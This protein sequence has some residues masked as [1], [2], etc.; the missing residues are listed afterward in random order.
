MEVNGNEITSAQQK[1]NTLQAEIDVAQWKIEGFKREI[2]YVLIKMETA[3]SENQMDHLVR[4]MKQLQ[5]NMRQFR[6]R[7]N[8]LMK[9]CYGRHDW[10][11]CAT[12][13]PTTNVS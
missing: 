3:T 4:D 13:R 11:V 6:E 5:E 2:E 8:V 7:R 10:R 9:S 1:I 12:A